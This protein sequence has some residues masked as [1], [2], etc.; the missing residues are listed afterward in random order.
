M[1]IPRFSSIKNFPKGILN[2]EQITAGEYEDVMKV[3]ILMIY[4]L[5][6]FMSRE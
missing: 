1:F 5:S 2:L 6:I 4:L 3:Y